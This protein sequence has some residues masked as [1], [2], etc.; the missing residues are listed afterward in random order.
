MTGQFHDIGCDPGMDLDGVMRNF[1]T[2][3]TTNFFGL[4]S[5]CTT[6][7]SP[8]HDTILIDLGMAQASTRVLIMSQSETDLGVNGWDLAPS[9]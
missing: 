4:S 8:S 5:L 9:L 3:F 6:F 1:Y 7:K 2:F